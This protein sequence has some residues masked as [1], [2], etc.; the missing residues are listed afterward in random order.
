MLALSNKRIEQIGDPTLADGILDWLVY[1]AR[2]DSLRKNRER[3]N[4]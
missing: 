4:A 1:N 2:R 3:P